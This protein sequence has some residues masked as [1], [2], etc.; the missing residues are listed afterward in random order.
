MAVLELGHE[1][2]LAGTSIP[3][4]AIARFFTRI[5]RV[6]AGEAGRT[7]S[8]GVRAEGPA[9]PGSESRAGSGCDRPR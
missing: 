7:G 6:C 2:R 3:G 8:S 5:L 1:N 9:V 4:P